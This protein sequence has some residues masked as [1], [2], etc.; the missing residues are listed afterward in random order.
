MNIHRRSAYARASGAH[1]RTCSFGGF[2][3][4]ARARRAPFRACS[5]GRV[6]VKNSALGISDVVS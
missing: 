4:Y 2:L 1:F 5:F 3:A 6:S